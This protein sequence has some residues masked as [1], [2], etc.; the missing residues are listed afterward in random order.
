MVY[1]C[2]YVENIWK[3]HIV[4][5]FLSY[6]PPYVYICTYIYIYQGKIQ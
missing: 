6:K 4:D 2:I 1:T 5:Y 3:Y